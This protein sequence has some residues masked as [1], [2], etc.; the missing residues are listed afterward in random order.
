MP[1]EGGAAHA[2]EGV[3]RH[4]HAADDTRHETAR[5]TRARRDPRARPR[6]RSRGTGCER[7]P[8][9]VRVAGMRVRQER[10][11]LSGPPGCAQ[12]PSAPDVVT[13]SRGCRIDLARVVPLGLVL[14]ARDERVELYGGL[15]QRRKLA[16]RR[17]EHTCPAREQQRIC[18]SCT[19]VDAVS[20]FSELVPGERLVVTTRVLLRP[21]VVIVRSPPSSTKVKPRRCRA[22]TLVEC[23]VIPRAVSSARASSAFSSFPRA[24]KKST[25]S[26]SFESYEQLP[27]TRRRRLPPT[28]PRRGRCLLAP[29]RPRPG[30]TPSTRCGPQRRRARGHA[31]KSTLERVGRG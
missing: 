2:G 9:A 21:I 28:S 25:E 17:D 12:P 16:C 19:E 1:H 6:E 10:R 24:V 30:R 14:P 13:T 29:A 4:Q 15:H 8:G 3:A 20:A 7:S 22:S 31:H 5:R 18:V 23:T 27:P 26:A 11:A